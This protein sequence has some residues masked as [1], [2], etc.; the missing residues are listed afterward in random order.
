M[1]KFEDAIRAI[2]PAII[3][4]EGLLGSLQSAY[5]AD[6]NELKSN[7]SV[8]ESVIKDRD[9]KLETVGNELTAAKLKNYD[10]LMELPTNE[11]PNEENVENDPLDADIDDLFEIERT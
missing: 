2:D 1:G 8:L 6:V 10:L 3:L 5:D 11:A 9:A 4:P 7:T